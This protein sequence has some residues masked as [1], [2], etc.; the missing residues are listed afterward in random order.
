MQFVSNVHEHLKIDVLPFVRRHPGNARLSLHSVVGHYY[1]PSVTRALERSPSV[2][3]EEEW[4]IVAA[5]LDR[6]ATNGILDNSA[7]PLFA[8]KVNADELVAG[9]IR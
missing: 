7:L 9:L 6:A 4:L 2:E 5:A 8:V 3:L 1:L